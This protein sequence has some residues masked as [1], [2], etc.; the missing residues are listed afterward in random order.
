[1]VGRRRAKQW[2]PWQLEFSE[3]CAIWEWVGGC[4]RSLGPV[5]HCIVPDALCQVAHGS[6]N[7]VVNQRVRSSLSGLTFSFK[8]IL[9]CC[10]HSKVS[11]QDHQLAY[12]IHTLIYIFFI[13]KNLGSAYDTED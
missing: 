4:R 12:N 11:L 3:A 13:V 5:Q 6:V 9:D 2:F 10:N 1:M 7:S 8:H